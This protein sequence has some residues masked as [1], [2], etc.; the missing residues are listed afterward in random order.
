[1]VG[2]ALPSCISHMDVFRLA[3]AYAECVQACSYLELLMCV[4][5]LLY[6][7][8]HVLCCLYETRATER[9]R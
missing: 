8:I 1:M 3:A 7:Y 5:L 6:C 4:H 9:G 2:E